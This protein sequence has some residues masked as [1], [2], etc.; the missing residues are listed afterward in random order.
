MIP[1]RIPELSTDLSY[2][3]IGENRKPGHFE[4]DELR[5]TGRSVITAAE[6]LP[7]IAVVARDTLSDAFALFH[8]EDFGKMAHSSI[9][10][11][12]PAKE[13]ERPTTEY[14]YFTLD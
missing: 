1:Q 8:F 13:S 11:V 14:V 5:F 7:E 4:I 3:T 6:I 10:I 9:P 12:T 2:C